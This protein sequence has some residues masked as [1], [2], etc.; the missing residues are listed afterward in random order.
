M[1]ISNTVP[2]FKVMHCTWEYMTL[3]VTVLVSVSSHCCFQASLKHL[4]LLVLPGHA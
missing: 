3:K 4:L 1:E 2:Q